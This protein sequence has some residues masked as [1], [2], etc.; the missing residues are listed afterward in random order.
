[1]V[2]WKNYEE[3]M[4]LHADGELS[5]QEHDALQHFVKLNPELQ[6]ELTAYESTKLLPDMSQVFAGKETLLKPVSTTKVL[7]LTSFV[8]YGAAAAVLFIIM[9][10]AFRWLHPGQEDQ[11]NIPAVAKEQPASSLPTAPEQPAIPQPLKTPYQEMTTKPAS[12]IVSSGP[13]VPAR[14]EVSRAERIG[15]I[16]SHSIK[17]LDVA[18]EAVPELQPLAITEIALAEPQPQLVPESNHGFLAW[19]PVNEEK[20]EGLQNLKDNVDSRLDHAR[21]IKDNL[22]ETSLALKLGGKEFVVINF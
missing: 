7:S 5:P 1:M 14:E 17:N 2:N 12:P 11:P 3:Y 20:K 22:K 16:A 21:S 8:R 13:V 18:S 6:E 9:L 4:L 19:L 15:S 10:V